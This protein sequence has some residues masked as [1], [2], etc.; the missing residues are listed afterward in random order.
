VRNCNANGSS[1]VG[2]RKDPISPLRGRIDDVIEHTQ[3][4]AE[5]GSDASGHGYVFRYEF[6]CRLDE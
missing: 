5:L 4:A 1:F 3:V 2:G 6:A